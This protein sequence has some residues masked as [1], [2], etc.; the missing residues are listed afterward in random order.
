MSKR[1]ISLMLVFAMVL[2]MFPMTVFANSENT[3]SSTVSTENPFKDVK[4]TDWCYDAVQYAR[5]NGFFNGTS[6]TTFNP[7]GTMTRGMFV[8]VLGRMAGVDTTAYDGQSAFWDVPVTKYYAPYVAWAAKHGITNGTGHGTFSPNALINRQQLAAFFVRYFEAFDVDYETGANITTIPADLDSVSDYAKDAVLKLWKQGLLNGDGTNFNPVSNASRAHAATLTM[9]ADQAVETWYKE[10]GVPSDRVK[11]DPAT[12]ESVK[13]GTGETPAAPSG[14]SSGIGGGA[15]TTSYYVE[16]LLGD[17]QSAAGVTLPASRT[18]ANNTPISQLPTPTVPQGTIFLGWYYDSAMTTPVGA[19]DCVTRAIKLYAKIVSGDQVVPME[20]PNYITED[21]VPSG[22][23]TFRVQGT[24]NVRSAIKF[25]NITGGNMTVDYTVSGDTVSAVLEAGQT[26]QVEL[27]DDEASFADQDVSVRYLN[28]LTAKSEIANASLDED[29]RKEDASTVTGLDDAVFDG[30]YQTDGQGNTRTNNTTGSFTTTEVYAVGETVA[31]TR[32][33]VNLT[34]V[35]SETG[36]VAYVKIVGVTE[37]PDGKYTYSYEMADVEDV[38]FMPDTLPIPVT[39]DEDDNTTNNS[40]TVS[41][42]EIV[43]AMSA[44]EAASID[45]GDYIAFYSGEWNDENTNVVQYAEI[46]EVTANGSSYTIAYE[47]YASA[48]AYEAALSADLDVY[49]E[50]DKDIELSEEETQQLKEDL[51]QDVQDSGYVEQAAMYLTAMMLESDNLNEL[52]DMEQINEM[53]G[54]MDIVATGT[55]DGFVLAGSSARVDFNWA[56]GQVRIDKNPEKLDANSGF[57]VEIRVP[58]T[59]R[60]NDKVAIDV[61]AEFQ[62][63]VV[64]KQKISTKRHKIGF[65][66]YDYSLNASFEVG[67]Y[68]GIDFSATVHTTDD[69]AASNELGK[70]LETILTVIKN[71]SESANME[72]GME[73]LSEAYQDLMKNAGD[74]W[75]DIID[76]QLFCSNGNAFLHIFCWQIK[77]SF[78]VSVNM[79]VAMGMTFEYITH[80]QYNYSVRVKARTATNET[81]DLVPAR[82]SFDFYV[83]GTLALRAGI[84]LEMYVGLFS[85]KLDK[86]GIT[87][88]AGA[89]VQLWGYFF[90]HKEWSE[91]LG[92]KSNSAG[93]MLVEIGIYIDIR[94]VAQLFSS[95]KLTYNPTLYAHQ[96]PLWSAGEVKNVY[97]FADTGDS[98]YAFTTV[99][100]L[101]LPSSTYLMKAMDLKSGKISSESRDDDRESSFLIAF[102]NPAFAYSPATNTVTVTPSAG[103]LEEET[104]MTITW[105]RAPLTFTSAPIQKV[106][107]LSWSDPEGV[108]YIAFDSMGGSAVEQLSAGSGAAI[109]WPA[110][111]TKQGYTFA[112]WY[113]DSSCTN[114]YSGSTTEMPTFAEGTKGLTLYAKWTP[115]TAS[116]MVEHYWQTVDGGYETEY[117]SKSGTVEALTV[118]SAKT[119]TG[120]TAKSLQEQIIAADGSTV[121]KVYYD[122]EKYNAVFHGGYDGAE[123]ITMSFVYGAEPSAPNMSREGYSFNGWNAELPDDMPAKDLDFTAQWTRNA[124][125]VTWKNGDSVLQ[126]DEGVE[127]GATPTY[128]GTTPT[129]AADAQYSY[130]FAGWNTKEDGSGT[131]VTAA[132]GPVTYYAQ[133]TKTVEKYTVIWKDGDTVLE[134]DENVEYGTMPSYDGDEPTKTATEQYNYVF[135]GW[136]TEKDG[137]GAAL[138]DTVTVT[139]AVTYYAQY[140]ETTNTYTVTWKNADGTVLETDEA[141][142]YGTTPS[143]DGATPTKAATAQFSYTFDKW[144]PEVSAVTGEVTYTATYTETTNAYTVTWKNADGT[145]LETDEDVLYGTEPSYDGATPTKAADAQYTYTFSGWDHLTTS[146]VTGNVTYTAVYTETLNKYTVKFVNEDG[147]ELQS[148]EVAYGETPAYTGATPTKTATEQYSYTFAGW[149]PSVS[150]VTGEATYT[151]QF[152]A[153]ARNYAITYEGMDGATNPNPATYTY[154]AGLA[155][156]APTKTGHSFAGWYDN[157]ECSGDAVTAISDADT[158]EKTFYAKWTANTYTITYDANG[159]SAVASGTYTYGIGLGELPTPTWDGYA[160][161]GWYDA[162]GTPYTT[163][164]TTQVGDLVLTA[165]WIDISTKYNIWVAGVQVTAA[166]KNDVLHGIEGCEEEVSYD[167]ANKVLTLNGMFNMVEELSHLTEFEPGKYAYVFIGEPVTIQLNGSNTINLNSESLQN[168]ALSELYNIYSTGDLTITESDSGSGSLFLYTGWSSDQDTNVGLRY[169]GS[170]TLDGCKLNI[171]NQENTGSGMYYGIEG[172]GSFTLRNQA[173]LNVLATVNGDVAANAVAFYSDSSVAMTFENLYYLTLEGS[174]AA[175]KNLSI[176]SDVD[177]TLYLGSSATDYAEETLTA[178]IPKSL[179]EYK[180]YRIGSK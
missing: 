153:V 38:L 26:Y 7:N 43:S 150:S 53:M 77:G 5:M 159:G 51:M 169:S 17:G 171:Q 148:S 72:T 147:T 106:I 19:N 60:L 56:N 66:K 42:A 23:Y 94:F 28:I 127:H 67:N 175:A 136:N 27:L 126:T 37:A 22:S 15:T 110:D 135:T 88:E 11:I 154:G 103:S 162:E 13:P 89:Y 61:V 140:A 99:K 8:T 18:Y 113:T 12:G 65:L 6:A 173:E 14:G 54:T 33:N 73:G 100:T 41:A 151:A 59:I 48:A 95:S 121:V 139:G 178:S 145:V 156:L 2:T 179:N 40:I 10:P 24:G 79:N 137:S 83:M 108:R 101:A 98:N 146:P 138:S 165:R 39:A 74:N 157:E 128:G 85:L 57:D 160:F 52:P 174:S 45:K 78:V 149:S 144:S 125:T 114:A 81:I 134:T 130:I 120:F 96:W 16:F 104:D 35:T 176:T 92:T 129:K 68:T 163:I 36:D 122:R 62:E 177:R 4:E 117:E 107:T 64:L 115:A 166:N 70:R 111:P 155:L 124:Y 161:D 87:A 31:F 1:L 97:A 75:V 25:I 119:A 30:L 180:Y 152:T 20:T 172:N 58:F 132:T 86:I 133:Y 109:S 63:E 116:Y 47:T 32:G 21:G 142:E 80:K 3:D 123:D 71:Q 9:R 93:A 141:V 164:S 90:Y 50:K 118:N 158:G 49:Y 29:L 76:Q 112:G 34:D 44:V 84:R 167:P 82:Y 91:N 102:S 105:K 55:D 46:T 131:T 168:A 143:Y 69:S 170:C